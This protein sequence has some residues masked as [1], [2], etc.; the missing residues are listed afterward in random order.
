MKVHYN[1]DNCGG[2]IAAIEVEALDE[3]RFGFDCLTE[4]ERQ[5]MVVY[6]DATHDFYVQSLCDDCIEAMG[7]GEAPAGN[8]LLH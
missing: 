7:L 4:E 5:A 3:A 2:F 1:C 6:D 8:T